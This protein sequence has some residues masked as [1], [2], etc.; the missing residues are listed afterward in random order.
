MQLVWHKTWIATE[1]LSFFRQGHFGGHEP[2]RQ[3]AGGP[4]TTETPPGPAAASATAQ[5]GRRAQRGRVVAIAR[6]VRR[7]WRRPHR[8]RRGHEDAAAAAAA[9]RQHHRGGRRR[10]HRVDVAQAERRA[11]RAGAHARGVLLRAGLRF[12]AHRHAGG[13]HLRP[14]L[15]A[16]QQIAVEVKV[17]RLVAVSIFHIKG[18]RIPNKRLVIFFFFLPYS[19]FEVF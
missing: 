4:T 8:G 18:R 13:R 10:R 19:C 2:H 17:Q 1:K 7:G 9:G 14:G 12:G 5:T 3:H 11:R 16:H 15:Q 6:V